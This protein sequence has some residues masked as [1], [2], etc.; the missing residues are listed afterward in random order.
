MPR[1][2]SKHKT[3]S[4]LPRNRRKL[5]WINLKN[6]I[7]KA[8]RENGA[9]FHTWDVIPESGAQWCDICF[10]SRRK[11]EFYNACIETA[12]AAWHRRIDEIAKER[13]LAYAVPESINDEIF[14][15]EGRILLPYDESVNGKSYFE[16]LDL[17]IAEA[18]KSGV[19]VFETYEILPD[20]AYGIGLEM[21]VDDP[22]LT[23]ESINSAIADFIEKGETDYFSEKPISFS[24]Y[25][26]S[27]S[28]SINLV[29][30][31]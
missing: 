29:K 18:A 24:E 28:F 22:F 19:S 10:L 26:S 21:I 31:D 25:S 7:S 23:V 11:G 6:E 2:Q 20:Y 15:E 9:K 27:A 3:F 30:I 4:Q 13:A 5:L 14:D 8:E 12:K 17:C 16:N 1:F